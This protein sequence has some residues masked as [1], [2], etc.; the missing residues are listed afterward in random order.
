M[1]TC[2]HQIQEEIIHEFSRLNGDAELT[3]C[4]LLKLGQYLPFMPASFKT[5][6]HIIKGCQSKVWLAA[7]LE[8]GKVN[9][10]ADSNTAITRGLI[11]LLIRIFN[12]QSPEAIINADLYFIQKS[13]LERFIGNQRSNGFA[14]MFK[15]MKLY[16]EDFYLTTEKRTE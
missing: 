16:A 7:R 11:S 10:Y 4:H 3:I 2:I 6:E 9:F 12:G 8:N 5:N 1:T 14:A 15:Q 13:G